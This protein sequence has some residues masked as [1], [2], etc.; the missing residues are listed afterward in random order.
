VSVVAV[1]TNQAQTAPNPASSESRS[2]LLSTDATPPSAPTLAGAGTSRPFQT[3]KEIE[4]SWGV[5]GGGYYDIRHRSAPDDAGFGNFFTWMAHTPMTAG[6]FT[7]A[8][9]RTYCFS[10]RATDAALN[11]SQ[12]GAER[13]T[14]VP[15]KNTSLTH[16]GQWAKK[17]GKGY[18]LGTFSLSSAN[19]AS[20]V[21]PKI[22][23]KRLA[24]VVT[25]CPRCGTIKVF[26]RSKLLRTIRLRAGSIRKRQIVDLAIFKAVR[27]GSLR[28]LVTSSGRP[29]KIEGVGVSAA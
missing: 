9:G 14:A 19:G 7:G 20:L 29:V 10:A 11:T 16:Q 23:A 13:C 8:P 15:V 2:Y 6:L 3:Q 28:A 18:F 12:Y 17:K 27:S 25:K 4:L 21:L 5:E 26:F 22:H 1:I 24:I